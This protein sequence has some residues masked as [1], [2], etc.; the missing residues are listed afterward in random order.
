MMPA[1][2]LRVFRQ[3]LRS[4]FAKDR[5]DA[6][7]G[8][9]LAFHFDQLIQENLAEGLSEEEA[10]HAAAR[11][12]GNPGVLEEQCRDQRRVRWLHDLGDDVRYG[13][14]M[15]R[16]SPG[17]TIVAVA[18]LALGIGANTAIVG[19]L[20]RMTFGTLPYPEADRIVMIRTFPFDD[21]GRQTNAS[22]P[23]FW[24]FREQ[25]KSFEAI[26]SSL[27]DQKTLGAS[28]DGHL[29]EKIFGQRFSPGLFETLGVPPM[30][31]RT[32][33]D[34]DF[35]AGP[36]LV[37]VLSFRLWQRRFGGDTEIIGKKIPLN[38]LPA[39]VIGVMPA[40]FRFAQGAAEY[41]LPMLV[42]R[43]TLQAGVRYQIVAARLKKDIAIGQAQAELDR[44]A[45]Q[46]ALEFPD[47]HLGWGVRVQPLREA[48]FGWV[49]ESL[50]T[51]ESAV[52]LVLLIACANVAGLLLARGESRRQELAM[53]A[54]LGAGR[55]RIVRQ[56]LTESMMLAL[57]G[58]AL[59]LA[60]ARLGLRAFA[61]MTPPPGA[62]RLTEIPL[63]YHM[64]LL[65]GLVSAATAL[66][67]GSGPALAVFRRDLTLT[68]KESSPSAGAPR[69]RR[70]LRGVLVSAQIAFAFVL[71]IGSGLLMESYTRLS[72]RALNMEPRGL[73][74][75][76]FRIPFERFLR[77]IG[78]YAGYP[79]LEVNPSASLKLHRILDRLRALPRVESVA[80]ISDPPI[81]SAIVPAM[82]LTAEGAAESAGETSYFLVTPN[83]FATLK[84]AFVRGRDFEDRDTAG[85]QWV[86]VI[87]ETAARRF[88]P[89]QDPIAKR[90][91]LDSVPDDQP[92]EV[93]GVVRDIPTRTRSAAPEPVVYLSYLQQPSR[94]RL[95]WANLMGQMTF[96]LRAKGNPVLLAEAAR[97]A[98]AEIDSDIPVANVAPMEQYTEG[99]LHD[100]FFYALTLGIFASVAASLAA[101][102]IYGALAYSVAQRTHEIGVRVSVGASSL[103]VARLVGQWTLIVSGIGLLGGVAGALGLTRLLESQLWQVKPTDLTAFVGAAVLMMAAAASACVIPVRR[104]LRVDPTIALRRE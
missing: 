76:E 46:L 56:L 93:I 27:A 32:F 29:P 33:V 1:R 66:V 68:L 74:T 89:G 104:A 100:L 82:T 5:L 60:I 40:D 71:L 16:K 8:R 51:L 22:A 55:G 72:G 42:Q 24:A 50:L 67:F 36:S 35:Q 28:E 96:V 99:Q 39:E 77:V 63:N 26:G 21:P 25:T 23:D 84:T 10:R 44:V 34:A 15:M 59:G 52:L 86:A 90:F 31:G 6:E 45:A 69:G 37:V 18:S 81:N 49:K 20:E 58:G 3:R 57:A 75:F 79:Y 101:I 53:R 97:K 91:T 43:T 65:T 14:R 92:R 80:G 87:N 102:G 9:E 47:S 103:A 54:A 70:G 78:E 83:L 7:L 13:W 41:W 17:F 98:V 2:L 62:P 19:A 88:W 95:P 64:V 4:L 11:M 94:Y 73:L 48:L 61:A 85:A 30:L 12:L 38:G